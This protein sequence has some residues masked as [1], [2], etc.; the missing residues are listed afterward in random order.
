MPKAKP[1]QVIVHRIE[2]QQSERDALEAALAG[3]FVTNAVSATGN[4]LT[5]VGNFLV[6]FSGVLTALAGVWIADRSIDQIVQDGQNRKREAE[7]SYEGTGAEVLSLVSSY[8]INSYADRGWN[9]NFNGLF[10][11]WYAQYYQNT[12]NPIIIHKWFYFEILKPFLQILDEP[13]AQASGSTPAELWDQYYSTTQYG[14]DAYFYNTNVGSSPSRTLAF[15]RQFQ[16]FIGLNVS[17]RGGY[18]NRDAFDPWI[19]YTG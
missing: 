18:T 14:K 13:N 6:P 16:E 11:D 17:E 3:R 12:N 2:L 8:L 19:P 1:T 4:V 10:N 5:G 9:F 15:L 7:R